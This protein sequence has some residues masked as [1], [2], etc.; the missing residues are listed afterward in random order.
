MFANIKLVSDDTIADATV[1]ETA[2]EGTDIITTIR[3]R[4][5][6]MR[7]Y[8]RFLLAKELFKHLVRSSHPSCLRFEN[9]PAEVLDIQANIFA[10]M[11]M[12]PGTM[13]RKEV[14]KIDAS[15]DLV[16]QMAETF[17]V[18]KALMNQRLRDYMEH[19]S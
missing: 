3:F 11:L 12:I 7:P 14:E 9:S 4:G 2:G 17:W 15:L 8:M 13:L 1:I 6:E 19:L 16:L 18:S 10:G 5:P